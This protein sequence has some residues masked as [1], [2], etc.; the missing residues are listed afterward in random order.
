[1]SH[2]YFHPR[3]GRF[4]SDCWFFSYRTYPT[5]TLNSVCSSAVF[6][7]FIA[8]C[9][10]MRYSESLC[11]GC[12]F[13]CRYTIKPKGCTSLEKQS[14]VALK[15]YYK[16]QKQHK[17]YDSLLIKPA[18]TNQQLSRPPH[19]DCFIPTAANNLLS[20]WSHGNRRYAIKMSF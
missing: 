2:L 4:Y 10:R 16:P 8:D 3:M 7:T 6:A 17:W 1:M 11:S 9:S 12:H 15:R 20:I 13:C 5:G 18:P 14:A 19:S